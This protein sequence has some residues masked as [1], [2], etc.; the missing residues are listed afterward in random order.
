MNYFPGGPFETFAPPGDGSNAAGG[1]SS[2]LFP[3]PYAE[4]AVGAHGFD[5]R[6]SYAEVDSS[7]A[8]EARNPLDKTAVCR[9]YTATGGM[10]PYGT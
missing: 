4:A 2:G 7:Q 10:C 5:A 9:N 6:L 3:P 8:F 1:Q